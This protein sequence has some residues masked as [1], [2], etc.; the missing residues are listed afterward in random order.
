MTDEQNGLGIKNVFDLVRKEIHGMFGTKNPTEER[1]R[2]YKRTE[3]EI[4]KKYRSDSKFKYVLGDH[5]SKII[6]NCRGLKKCNDEM[7]RMKKEEE[8]KNFRAVLGLKEHDI[9][10]TEEE[11]IIST[12]MKV[13]AK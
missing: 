8:K 4:D 12:I 3:K 5:M 9:M 1:F 6:K 2:K 13:F 10:I 11:S 7:N